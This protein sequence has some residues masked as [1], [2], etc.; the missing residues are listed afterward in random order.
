MPAVHRWGSQKAAADGAGDCAC[1]L[2]PGHEIESQWL[3]SEG[4]AGVGCL[5]LAVSWCSFRPEC[6]DMGQIAT[7]FS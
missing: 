1:V 3:A 7:A 5:S 4:S 6:T 2:E